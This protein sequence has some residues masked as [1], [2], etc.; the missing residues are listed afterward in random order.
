MLLIGTDMSRAGACLATL[1]FLAE[2]Q[3][4]IFER[5]SRRW[6]CRTGP[7]KHGSMEFRRFG[8][9]GMD[10]FLSLLFFFSRLSNLW[11]LLMFMMMVFMIYF[12]N[13]VVVCRW[14][15]SFRASVLSFNLDST[16]LKS[17]MWLSVS[18][19]ASISAHRMSIL[20][21]NVKQVLVLPNL[22]SYACIDRSLP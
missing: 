16:L 10:G 12:S 15:W 1:L 3:R 20:I 8:A 7:K 22:H 18:M 17:R 6:V 11:I 13:F 9:V 4:V 19:N 14:S 21:H 5:W 2:P